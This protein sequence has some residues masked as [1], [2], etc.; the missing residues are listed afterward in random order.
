MKLFPIILVAFVLMASS[1][2]RPDLWSPREL[3]LH[4]VAVDNADIAE[5]CAAGS[6][7]ERICRPREGC[8]NEAARVARA[9]KYAKFCS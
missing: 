8:E 4:K 5:F 6:K 1:L 3:A 2:M 7:P 9:Q